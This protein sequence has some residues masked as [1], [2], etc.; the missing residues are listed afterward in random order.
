MEPHSGVAAHSLSASP[1][2]K[3]SSNGQRRRAQ[4]V[5]RIVE[6]ASAAMIGMTGEDGSRPIELLSQH[7]AGK[8]VRQRHGPQ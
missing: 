2:R 1:T 5:Q 7:N 4:P 6:A 8:P 3:L